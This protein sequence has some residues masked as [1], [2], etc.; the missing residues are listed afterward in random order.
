MTTKKAASKSEAKTTANAKKN[1]EAEVSGSESG[2]AV[3]NRLLQNRE[4]R[5]IAENAAYSRSQFFQQFLD[6]RRNIYDECGYPTTEG[7]T[8]EELKKTYEREAIANRIV[9]VMPKEAWQVQPTIIE[10][11]D[12]ETDT[13]FEVALKELGK[14]LGG[15]SWHVQDEGSPLWEYLLRVDILSGI[16]TYGAMLVGLDDG[17]ELREPAAG[18]NE[19]GEATKEKTERKVLYLR[20]FDESLARI[21]KYE[22]DR[23]NPRF[24][25]PTEYSL[26]FSSPS[27]AT[28]GVAQGGGLEISTQEVHWSRVIH[29]TDGLSS[30]EVHNPSRLLPVYNRVSDLMKLL[31]G[32]AEMYWK[33][34]FPGLAIETHPQLGGDVDIDRADMKSQLEDYYTGLQRYLSLVGLTAKSLAPQV[35]DPSPQIEVQINQ[36]CIEIGVPKRI[37]VGSE[38]GE[39][40]SSQDDSQWND[41]L[42]NRQNLYLTPRV[43]VPTIDRFIMLGALPEPKEYSVVWPDLEAL[44]ELEQAEIALKRTEA[45]AK[46]V[47]GNVGV[48][49]EPVDFYTRI[50][51]LPNEEAD[52]ILDGVEV[53]RFTLEDESDESVVDARGNL[54]K[55]DRKEER[56]A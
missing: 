33:G 20:C 31:S 52:A 30:S 1:G 44:T 19:K 35:V 53:P 10:D 49:M 4:F 29:Y 17:K 37:L 16:G 32:S 12:V 25:K 42:R 27:R 34:A 23:N 41:R 6:P 9:E 55:K 21:T 11:D 39:L 15:S 14:S 56:G 18:I 28:Q 43:V 51:A 40:A 54:S 24:G 38:R 26:S 50:L 47:G 7:L 22:G 36:I 3:L 45:L 13:D 8:A 2:R 48:I 5:N 46:Y